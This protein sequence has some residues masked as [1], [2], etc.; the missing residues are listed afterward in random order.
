MNDKGWIVPYLKE[1]KLLLICVVLL[2]LVTVFAASFLMFT[3]G[4]LISKAATRPENLLLIYIPI[5]GVRTFGI[6][7]AVSRYVERLVGHNV[8]LKILSNMRVKVYRN[9]E[10]NVL[11]PSMKIKTGDVLGLL[12]DDIERLQDI[13]VK[14]VFPSLVGLFLYGICIIVLGL[15]SW[16][17]AILVAILAGVLV[18]LFPFVSLLVTKA[19]VK[20]IKNNR[21]TLYEKLTDAI[22]GISEWQFSGRQA[23]FIKDY[24]SQEHELLLLEQKRA[25]FIRWRF[26][27]AQVVI[28]SMVVVMLFWTAA[29][30]SGGAFAHTL[31]AA[32]VLVLFPLTEAFV[33]LSDAVSEIPSYQDSIDRLSR[34]PDSNETKQEDIIKDTCN[35]KLQLKNVSFQYEENQTVNNVSFTMNQGDIIALLGPSG[36]G[37]STIMK[38]IQGVL[39]PSSGS[40]TMNGVHTSQVGSFIPNLIAILQQQPHLFDTTILNNIRLGNPNASDEDVYEAA[41]QVK[42]HDYISSLPKGYHTPMHET[43]MRFSGGERQRVALAR[44]LLQDTPVVI[45]DEPTVGLD[46]ITEKQLMTTVFEVLQGKTILWITHHLAFV[47][48]ADQVLFLDK[49][50]IVLQGTHE[51]LMN[52][53]TRYARLYEL[54]MPRSKSVV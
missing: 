31:I 23:A 25:S 30:T 28:A 26:S 12:A 54:D 41:K 39:L 21:H 33:P 24:E 22:L 50:E 38:L 14:T 34:L 51:Q 6:T 49:G 32:F 18:F 8:V 40:V 53:N 52:T 15:F 27:L 20:K 2:G 11:H 35:I 17:F 9:I 45:L 46:P 43:G 10:P 37:K 4:Y 47:H 36:A 3:S 13:Y 5:V 1:N 48:M 16:P 44:I 29:E 42:L 19:T 7:R